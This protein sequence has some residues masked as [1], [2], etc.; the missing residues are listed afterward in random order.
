MKRAARITLVA[1][2]FTAACS[3]ESVG[4]DVVDSAVQPGSADELRESVPCDELDGF[5]CS[6]LVVP[7]DHSGGVSGSLDLAVAASDNVDAPQGVLLFLAGGPGQPGVATLPRVRNRYLDAD[8]LTGYRLVMFDQR[9]TGQGAIDCEELQSAV[10][11]SDVL[12]PPADAVTEC[13]AELGAQRKFYSTPDTVADIEL[14]RK[15][16]GVER[17]AVNGVSYGTFTAAHYALTHPD[18]VSKL[19][20]DSVVPQDG[21]DPLGLDTFQATGHVLADACESAGCDTDPVADLAWLVRQGEIDGEPVDGVRLVEALGIT[22][23]S[24]IDPAFSAVPGILAEAR[25]GD[26]GRLTE[27]LDSYT[28]LGAPAEELSA[29]LHMATLCADLRFPWGDSA[30]DPASRTAALDETVAELDSDDVYPFDAETARSMQPVQ[31]CLVWPRARPAGY[32]DATEIRPP[33]LIV[34]GD[35]DLL[36]PLAWA[37]RQAKHLADGEL[38]VVEG[39]GHG[40]QASDD[41]VARD[42]VTAFLLG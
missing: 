30:T 16:L 28:A 6:T 18:R 35:R 40:V 36:T 17:L 33:T 9:G 1:A 15:T 42:A 14:L 5:T 27:L 2:S 23:L 3:S 29:G 21:F 41:P 32:S 20:L 24:T 22:S 4:R 38:V 31:G 37:R 39:A 11:G 19:V 8:V 25:A 10:G 7:L 34:A 12:T 26:A 13:A